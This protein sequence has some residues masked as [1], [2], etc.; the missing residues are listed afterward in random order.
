MLTSEQPFGILQ[1]HRKY[2]RMFEI[3]YNIEC[4]LD[5]Q[6]DSRMDSMNKHTKMLL[7]GI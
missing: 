2:E 6:M 7:V 5:Y 1:S 3:C 4:L